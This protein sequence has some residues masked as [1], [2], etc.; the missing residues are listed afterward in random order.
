MFDKK[1]SERETVFWVRN[2]QVLKS[3]SNGIFQIKE[4]LN[5]YD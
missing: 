3:F 2:S 1:N 4:D 5:S